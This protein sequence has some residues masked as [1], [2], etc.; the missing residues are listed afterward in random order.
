MGDSY[1]HDIHI[2]I[3]VDGS[4]TILPWKRPLI[5]EEHKKSRVG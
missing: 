5:R 2:E 3:K 4:I 1:L